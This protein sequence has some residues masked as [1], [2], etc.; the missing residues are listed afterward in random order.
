MQDIKI[1]PHFHGISFC[2]VDIQNREGIFDLYKNGNVPYYSEMIFK[3]AFLNYDK[4]LSKYDIKLMED[5]YVGEVENVFNNRDIMTQKEFLEFS[6]H[7]VN[8]YKSCAGSTTFF[9]EQSKEPSDNITLDKQSKEHFRNPYKQLEESL[10]SKYNE[11]QNY[12]NYTLKSIE[13]YSPKVKEKIKNIKLIRDECCAAILDI[14]GKKNKT[15]ER[16]NIK[17]NFQFLCNKENENMEDNAYD[18]FIATSKFPFHPIKFAIN[19]NKKDEFEEQFKLFKDVNAQYL[20]LGMVFC[21]FYSKKKYNKEL[22]HDIPQ[23]KHSK[24]VNYNCRYLYQTEVDFYK[25]NPQNFKF[26]FPILLIKNNIPE[27][28]KQNIKEKF[29]LNEDEY[30]MILQCS[31]YNRRYTQQTFIV[32]NTIFDNICENYSKLILRKAKDLLNENEKLY[33]LNPINEFVEIEDEN[34]LNDYTNDVHALSRTGNGNG[35]I[36]DQQPKKILDIENLKDRFVTVKND[37]FN[38]IKEKEDLEEARKLLSEKV[39][40]EKYETVCASRIV[41]KLANGRNTVEKNDAKTAK[42]L[43]KRE[44][45]RYRDMVKNKQVNLGEFFES[46]GI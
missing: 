4:K 21:S 43:Q 33:Y 32:P 45:R 26:A 27:N 2:D 5:F 16:E 13:T 23:I 38:I 1:I 3:N 35:I 39:S 34:R 10:N 7:Y 20:L 11:K 31:P 24:N 6:R 41:S 19:N 18:P 14:R 46:I 15:N 17:D 30:N 44:N 12:E 29:N 9:D 40:E 36:V 37:I 22:K 8:N 28:D 25:I 42:I